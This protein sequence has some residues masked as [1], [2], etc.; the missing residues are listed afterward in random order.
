MDAIHL[1][2]WNR[3]E[4]VPEFARILFAVEGQ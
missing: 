3:K 2:D 1:R 4:T